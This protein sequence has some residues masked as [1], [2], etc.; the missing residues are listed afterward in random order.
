MGEEPQ[1]ACAPVYNTMSMKSAHR[2][3]E[4]EVEERTLKSRSKRC[5]TTNLIMSDIN[6]KLCCRNMT[7]NDN[8][9]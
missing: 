5:L 6:D 1:G 2:N 3:R 4:E 9:M 8:D 7:V